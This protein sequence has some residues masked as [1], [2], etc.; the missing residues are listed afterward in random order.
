MKRIIIEKL[1]IYSIAFVVLYLASA[2][3]GTKITKMEDEY[4]KNIYEV[5]EEY[6]YIEQKPYR[7]S[8]VDELVFLQGDNRVDIEY[9]VNEQELILRNLFVVIDLDY[10]DNLSETYSFLNKLYNEDVTKYD[11]EIKQMIANYTEK[12][13]EQFFED[14]DKD[15]Q[16]I[17]RINKPKSDEKGFQLYYVINY[18]I[19]KAKSF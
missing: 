2:S 8:I 15:R 6:N 17:L 9:Y 4:R 18:F 5:M 3:A 11:N 16:L 12:N 10:S 14:L 13:E 19:S 1:L 7:P